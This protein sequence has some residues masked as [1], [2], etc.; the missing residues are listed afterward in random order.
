MRQKSFR[1]CVGLSKI[2]EATASVEPIIAE[3]IETII[4][5]IIMNGR[6]LPI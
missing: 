3:D 6:L 2:V 5:P 1:S 4:A